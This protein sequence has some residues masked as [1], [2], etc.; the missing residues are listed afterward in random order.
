MIGW[1]PVTQ[2]FNPYFILGSYIFFLAVIYLF[3][4]AYLSKSLNLSEKSYK[5][6]KIQY[7]NPK[8]GWGSRKIP[9]QYI[10]ISIIS[11]P[12]TMLSPWP[13]PKPLAGS[14]SPCYVTSCSVCPGISVAVVA[15]G[16]GAEWEEGGG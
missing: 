1:V 5:M 2:G 4:T 15:G 12:S 13:A 6:I 11:L 3:V 16:G 10:F 7:S 9:R 8:P 14:L